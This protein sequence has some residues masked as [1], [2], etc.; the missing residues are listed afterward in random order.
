MSKKNKLLLLICCLFFFLIGGVTFYS[1]N[2]NSTNNFIS[3]II[4]KASPDK[5]SVAKATIAT[6]CN[7]KDTVCVQKGGEIISEKPQEKEKACEKTKDCHLV[8]SAN[9]RAAITAIRAYTG[10]PD[11]NLNPLV[12]DSSP[13]N[14]TYYCNDSNRCWA[15]DHVTHKVIEKN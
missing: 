12:K 15:V 14:I 7:G 2:S 11:M 1:F 6:K 4:N 5:G 10:V 13:D 3:D 9:E 8:Y